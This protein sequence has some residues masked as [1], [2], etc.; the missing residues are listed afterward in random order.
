[1][2]HLLL[3]NGVTSIGTK[4]FY[5]CDN[6]KTVTL[7]STLTNIDPDA[8]Y[9]CTQLL[10]VNFPDNL[11]TIGSN[12]FKYCESLRH[13][14]LP[15]SLTLLGG[16]AFSNLGLIFS[17]YSCF[18]GITNLSHDVFYHCDSMPYVTIPN[19]VLAM[20]QL[21]FGYC[22]A[23]NKVD[24]TALDH[25]PYI[26]SNTFQGSTSCK[27]VV[28]NAAMKTAFQSATNWSALADRIVTREEYG[29]G[30]S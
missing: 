21:A 14:D 28:S 5:H 12:A 29:N 17:S 25:V 20:G 1:M 8:F 16:S 26:Q 2:E 9:H 23:L 13:I 24:L 4:A 15:S 3:L 7:P 11:T 30:N 27:F 6:L 18:E 19:S 22:Y 10:S